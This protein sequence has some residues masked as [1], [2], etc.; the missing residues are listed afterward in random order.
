MER[1]ETFKIPQAQLDE[2]YEKMCIPVG[3]EFT[4]TKEALY[5]IANKLSQEQEAI[6][7]RSGCFDREDVHKG[8][9]RNVLRA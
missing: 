4:P 6:V 1:T 3:F 9:G 5:F 8:S 2:L 7:N